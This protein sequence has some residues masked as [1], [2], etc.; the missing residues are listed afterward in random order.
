MTENAHDDREFLARLEA[1]AEE[2]ASLRNRI[3]RT[4]QAGSETE[5][6]ARLLEE[7]GKRVSAL[8][9]RG[10]EEVTQSGRRDPLA[11]AALAFG[12]GLLLG[13]LTRRK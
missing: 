11:A 3:D 4:A 2:V 10:V 7:T 8:W 1:L 5:R 9:D 12:A 13:A 6:I